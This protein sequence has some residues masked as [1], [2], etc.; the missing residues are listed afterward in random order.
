M[1]LLTQSRV[2]SAPK[3]AACTD[4]DAGKGTYE[5]SHTWPAKMVA[6]GVTLADLFTAVRVALLSGD[7][8]RANV[9]EQT[10]LTQ[11]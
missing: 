9:E 2:I 3:L 1:L 5:P 10:G 7:R 11:R 8:Q 4:T 6:L